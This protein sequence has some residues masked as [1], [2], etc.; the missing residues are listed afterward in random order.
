MCSMEEEYESRF[1]AIQALVSDAKIL[2]ASE[3]LHSLRSFLSDRGAADLSIKLSSSPLSAEVEFKS[4][5]I[6]ESMTL[7]EAAE[8]WKACRTS[9]K[10]EV[11]YSLDEFSGLHKFW[12]S[13]TIKVPLFNAIAV[14]Y[15]IDLYEKWVPRIKFARELGSDSRFDK[16]VHVEL[17][18]I[19]PVANRDFVV[20]G[21]GVDWMEKNSILI[22]VS[23]KQE[24]PTIE[25]PNPQGNVVR[26]D[27]KIGAF[28]LEY[29]GEEECKC[30]L[31]I[32]V[33]PQMKNIPDW[34]LNF[35]TGQVLG[36]F[37][38][39]MGKAANFGPESEYSKRIK[40]NAGIYDY[41]REVIRNAKRHPLPAV[42]PEVETE[43]IV[44]AVPNLA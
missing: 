30:S 23:T 4:R 10:A 22:I 31:I 17:N 2:Q 39:F 34:L 35:C 43:E 7:F 32:N 28:R 1:L 29:A 18:A 24:H 44:N 25:I 19:W 38:H 3:S 37:F 20:Q 5:L 33:D 27:V 42:A 41:A 13:S 6:S 36:W 15:E 8:G 11:R 16:L 26:A 12:V 40:E 21:F 9:G 14:V